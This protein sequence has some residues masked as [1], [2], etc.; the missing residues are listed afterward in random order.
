MAADGYIAGYAA[1]D[2][3]KQNHVASR[4]RNWHVE[5]HPAYMTALTG[6]IQQAVFVAAQVSECLE[7]V[8]W[9]N[10]HVNFNLSL[11]QFVRS[12]NHPGT[13]AAT[14]EWDRKSQMPKFIA[15]R[16]HPPQDPAQP[17]GPK[18]SDDKSRSKKQEP[19]WYRD[20]RTEF[21]ALYGD[22]FVWK[23][24]DQN[25]PPPKY[26]CNSWWSTALQPREADPVTYYDIVMEDSHTDAEV[27]IGL[28]C[29][30]WPHRL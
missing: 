12:N 15:Q 25:D 10:E 5:S 26:K 8:K 24:V 4:E 20:H 18:T 17:T 13:V 7:T 22:T 28:S 6:E 30:C 14:G 16:V 2:P 23:P 21:K 11:D 9:C 19:D 3:R 1:Q 27:A 29:P